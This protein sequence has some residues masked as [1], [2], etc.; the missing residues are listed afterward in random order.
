MHVARHPWPLLLAALLCA[1]TVPAQ[2]AARPATETA[3]WWQAGV[4]GL[5]VLGNADASQVSAVADALVRAR[6]AFAA[7]TRDG[8]PG[9]PSPLV[10]FL[11]R[12]EES[13]ARFRPLY[14]GRAVE[15]GGAYLPG[16]EQHFITV[17]ASGSGELPWRTLY[18]EFS[19]F[20]TRQAWPH[21]PAWF[22][23]GLAEFH[24]TLD[25]PAGA[26]TLEAG[27]P[28]PAH[29]RVLEREPRLPLADLLAVTR[30]SALYN[31]G[32][33][34]GMFYAQSWLTVHYLL[35]GNRERTP[36]LMAYLRALEGGQSPLDAFD[37]AFSAPPAVLEKELADYLNRGRFPVLRVALQTPT[38][39][40]PTEARELVPADAE[41]WLAEL[42]LRLDR[43]HEARERLERGLAF[44][45]RHARGLSALGELALRE[46]QPGEARSLL[47][48]AAALAPDDAL[49]QVRWARMLLTQLQMAPDAAA[50]RD[51]LRA[52]EDAARRVLAAP[53]AGRTVHKAARA[54][55]EAAQAALRAQDR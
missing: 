14:E 32:D 9:A 8:E 25:L 36:Q 26:T 22:D 24:A 40:R 37:R 55:L 19:H 48:R 34:R 13:A 54:W 28:T 53:T 35:A 1:R 11:F 2:P 39:A 42:L 33:Q 15:V 43:V 46:Q 17:A 31:E 41:A 18:H 6:H 3:R 38:V 45:A 27:R 16:D 29:L 49:V 44:D 23:E 5:L 51:D 12:D 21:P 50:R 7:A 4:P 20:V 10:V 52:L 47:S 30:E